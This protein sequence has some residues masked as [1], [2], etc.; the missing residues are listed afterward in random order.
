MPR[1]MYYLLSS[2]QWTALKSFLLVSVSLLVLVLY[3]AA[4]PLV[5]LV[6][7]SVIGSLDAQ[8]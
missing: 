2:F 1:L 4:V 3:G 7:S 6:F 5:V 8:S